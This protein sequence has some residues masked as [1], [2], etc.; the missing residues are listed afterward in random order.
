MEQTDFIMIVIFTIVAILGLIIVVLQKKGIV[1]PFLTQNAFD[2]SLVSGGK[3][4]LFALLLGAVVMG[5]Y[6]ICITILYLVVFASI[7][8]LIKFLP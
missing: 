7:Y 2:F 5:K 1:R 8:A 4:T 3:I 6:S